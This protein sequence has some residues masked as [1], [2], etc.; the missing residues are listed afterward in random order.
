DSYRIDKSQLRVLRAEVDAL[1]FF[2]DNEYSSALT[3]GYSL[4]GLWVRP[5]LLY[6]PLRQVEVELGA[7]RSS[8]TEP[9]SIPATS[10]TTLAAGRGNNINTER[11]LCH[12]SEPRPSSAI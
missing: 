8:L 10:I 6:T 1:A 3:K 7:H 9:T 11:T 12:G 4:P 2:R 5:K